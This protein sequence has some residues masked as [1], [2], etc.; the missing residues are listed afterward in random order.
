MK[1]ENYFLNYHELVLSRILQ[2]K[3]K[4]YSHQRDGLLAIYQKAMRGEMSGTNRNAALILAGVGTGK[5]LIQA[6]TPFILAPWLTGQQALFLS[7]NCTLRS[8]F[9]RD[10]PTNS[11][12]C[13]LYDQW[14]LYSLDILPP[15]VPPPTIVELDAGNF[16][17]YAYAMYEADMLIG[18]RQFVVNLVSRGD[19]EPEKVGVLVVDEAHF[20]AAVS[21]R[22]ITNY[23]SRSLLTYF[24]GSKFRSDSQPLP[25]VNYTEVEEWNE[26]GHPAIGYAPIADY[27]F[28]LQDAW[29]LNP[30]P[31]KKLTLSEATSEAFL[32]EENGLEISYTPEA[33]FL[34]A[35]TDKL[36]F[37][38]IVFA[39]SFSLPVLHKA[40]EVLQKK[41]KATKQPHAMIVR[42]LNIPHVH[43]VAQL[44][45]D[46]F[47]QLQGRVGL[48][49]SER[50]N[51][52]LAGRPSDILQRFYNG[53]L[54]VLV[55]CGMVGVG[56]DHK[57]ASVSCCLGIIKS[58]SPAEQEWGRIIRRVPGAAPGH[59]SELEH[60]NW[61]VVVTHESLQIRPLF[62]EFLRGKA[63]DIITD[64][65]T[66]PRPQPVLTTGYEAGETVLTLSDTNTL[67]PGD[68]LQLQ[69][70]TISPTPA[71]PK[72]NLKE[73]L[74]AT[75]SLSVAE[76]EDNYEI[77]KE[78]VEAA[79][80]ATPQLTTNN[81]AQKPP[82]P[83]EAEAEAIHNRLEEIRTQRTYNVQVEAVLDQKKVQIT[84]LWSDL[85]KGVRVKRSRTPQPLPDS[86]FLSHINLDWQVFVNGELVSY[87]NYQRRILLQSKGLDLNEAGEITSA[88]QPLTATLPP[89]VYEMFIKGLETELATTEIQIPHQDKIARLDK[90]KLE[91]QGR[92][93]TQVKS[94][95]HDL[96]KQR[97]LIPDGVSG[98]S[99]IEKPIKLLA[100]AITRNKQKPDGVEFRN[101]QQLIHAAV[102]GYIKETTGR[103][104]GQHNEQQYKEAYGLARGYLMRLQEQLTWRKRALI[105]NSNSTVK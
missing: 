71:P 74:Q 64:I 7:D 84:P 89:A 47:P 90:A 51:Y 103:S 104:W 68:V 49:H 53:D 50:D 95:I 91:M 76:V 105:S 70:T 34:K 16:A 6:L 21:Y 35:E 77:T 31:I 40:V 73:E 10:F 29:K 80:T 56:F 46:N 37:R 42:A 22:T 38:Q 27:E 4:L 94:L 36:W 11:V 82:L 79:H 62:E 3:T 61:G 2:N 57:W 52:D 48:I 43:R 81:P 20:S 28:S 102:F 30:P 65:P 101:N 63:S 23:F 78:E 60:P 33:F 75:G 87:Q 32:V 72:F 93:G 83:W 39:N 41:R 44:L 85:P 45:N 59:F 17:S 12:G 9:L 15:G 96:F 100:E 24:T 58:L 86:H 18:N 99:L 26:L 25:H 19:I 5:T 13:P 88:G 66:P 69:A 54:W 1:L 67:Q 14:L 98:N 97:R 92:Y 8:R 55:H